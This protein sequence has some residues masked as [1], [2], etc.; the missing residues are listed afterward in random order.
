MISS[1]EINNRK[2]YKLFAD[3]LVY[4]ITFSLF[5]TA[6]ILLHYGFESAE[7]FIRPYNKN[8]SVEFKQNTSVF[9]YFFVK[10]GLL[11]S[12]SK[13]TDFL[14][15]YTEYFYITKKPIAAIAYKRLIIDCCIN[16]EYI[17]ALNHFITFIKKNK[18]PAFLR[19][20][21]RMTCIEV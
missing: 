16:K 21:L 2:N 19:D 11:F 20:T 1:Y 7:D 13:F 9:S 10:T 12:I 4:E 14:K 17:Q 8:K 15:R 18:I 5:Q 6:K 3:F